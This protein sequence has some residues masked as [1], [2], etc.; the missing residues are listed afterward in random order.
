[1]KISGKLIIIAFAVIVVGL[2]VW[3][4]LTLA[5]HN[6]ASVPWA[7][8]DNIITKIAE[9]AGRQARAPLINTDQGDL[10]LFI[11]AMGGAVGGFIIGYL[12]RKLISEKAKKQG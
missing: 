5:G 11:F 8:A 10:L 6:Q 3:G 1:M 7:G 9:D 12:W 4:W 2:A